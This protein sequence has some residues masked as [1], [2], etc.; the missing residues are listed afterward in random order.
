MP[1]CLSGTPQSVP[2]ARDTLLLRLF[3]S[4]SLRFS[5]CYHPTLSP[6][7]HPLRGRLQ[8]WTEGGMS[9]VFYGALITP[10][11]LTETRALPRA[12]LSVSRATGDIE[13][14][15]DD[16]AVDDI[17]SILARHG[18]ASES[19]DLVHLKLGEFLIPGFVDTHIVS[20]RSAASGRGRGVLIPINYMIA[21]A[22]SPEP[23]K[24][25]GLVA[26]CPTTVL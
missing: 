14:I 17:Q 6:N 24:V 4:L 16:V 21:C 18:A 15:E 13:W 19:V 23:W 12:L 2:V 26:P 22:A 3:A 25:C 9:T 10:T 8:D 1:G 20:L 11:T 7:H 5:F